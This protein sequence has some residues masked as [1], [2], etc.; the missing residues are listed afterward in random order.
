MPHLPANLSDAPVEAVIARTDPNEQESVV[1]LPELD[2]CRTCPRPR[3]RRTCR[4][5]SG[6][7]CDSRCR[8]TSGA[9]RRSRA[10]SARGSTRPPERCW[11]RSSPIAAAASRPSRDV[12]L[13]ELLDEAGLDRVRGPHARVA[14]GLQLEAHRAGALALAVAADA[15]VRAQQV[16]DVVAV[17]VGDHVGLGE[18]AALR[19]EARAQLVVEAQVDV[20]RLVGRAVERADGRGRAAAAGRRLAAEEARRRLAVA[21]E[22]ARSS[23]P[24]P[25]SRRRRSGS[26]RAGWRRRRSGRWSRGRWRAP[27]SPSRASTGPSRPGRSRRARP[28]R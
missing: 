20:D 18:R 26:P 13:G 25:S 1:V 27:A 11:M 21:V 4:S 15:L 28:A 5:G 22:R 3:R 9:R 8:T 17:L 6:R 19:A 24:A 16:L 2:A 7:R 14:V 12:G 23:S 10:S